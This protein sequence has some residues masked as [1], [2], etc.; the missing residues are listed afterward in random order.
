MLWVTVSYVVNVLW[1]LRL[2][3]VKTCRLCSVE[4]P[5]ESFQFRKDSNKHRTECEQCRSTVTAAKRYGVTVGFVENLKETQGNCC[6][7]CKI[8]SSVISHESFKYNP[9]VID[10]DHKTGKV[11][12]LLCPTCNNM[13]GHAKDSI[14]TLQ[15]AI[16]YLTQ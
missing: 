12:G 4:K 3:R 7:I 11:R 8:H 16:Q 13:L 1:N 10:H 14:E 9:L 2:P 6:A 15:A 5:L